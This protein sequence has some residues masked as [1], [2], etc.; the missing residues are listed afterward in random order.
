MDLATDSAGVTAG[1]G[2]DSAFC[3]WCSRSPRLWGLG[4]GGHE[5]ESEREEGENVREIYNCQ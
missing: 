4:R 3:F 2:A 1:L 5:C